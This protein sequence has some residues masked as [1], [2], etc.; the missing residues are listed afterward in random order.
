M[1][2]VLR[3]INYAS[4]TI[5]HASVVRARDQKVQRVN[6]YL[7]K[8]LDGVRKRREEMVSTNPRERGSDLGCDCRAFL[9][10]S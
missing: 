2:E 4:L 10:R 7:L 1:S 9:V 8:F 3:G 6:Y 5:L